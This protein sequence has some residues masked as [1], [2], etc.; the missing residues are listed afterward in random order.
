LGDNGI[1]FAAGAAFSGAK[2]EYADSYNLTATK[3]KYKGKEL[4]RSLRS[5]RAKASM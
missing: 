3:P 1:G 5:Y 4:E 2:Y